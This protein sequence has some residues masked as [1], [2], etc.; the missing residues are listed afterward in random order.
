MAGFGCASTRP[1]YFPVA[2]VQEGCTAG[3]GDASTRPTY[4]PMTL[5][6]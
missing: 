5:I 2:L 4:F 3:F 1:T 6:Q